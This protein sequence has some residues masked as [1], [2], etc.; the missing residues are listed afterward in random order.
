MPKAKDE[1]REKEF[2]SLPQ[3][4]SLILPAPSSE[5][6]KAGAETRLQ[7]VKTMVGLAVQ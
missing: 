5:G 3:S 6:A 1:G 4:K 7:A 2:L